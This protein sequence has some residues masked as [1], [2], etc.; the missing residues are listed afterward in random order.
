LARLPVSLDGLPSP[1]VRETGRSKNGNENVSPCPIRAAAPGRNRHGVAVAS[2]ASLSGSAFA[3]PTA[4]SP[5]LASAAAPS[6]PHVTVDRARGAAD[7]SKWLTPAVRA[8]I[9]KAGIAAAAA[10]PSVAVAFSGFAWCGDDVAVQWPAYDSTHDVTITVPA[11]MWSGNPQDPPPWNVVVAPFYV[12]QVGTDITFHYLDGVTPP[13]GPYDYWNAW[14]EWSA[15]SPGFFVQLVNVIWTMDNG[16]LSLPDIQVVQASVRTQLRR[17]SAISSAPRS[18]RARPRPARAGA[19]P[20]A[21][22]AIDTRLA[23][24]TV[25]SR[26]LVPDDQNSASRVHPRLRLTA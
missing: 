8:K 6:G 15:P 18:A 11:I 25:R 4:V 13:D 16:Q 14:T 1:P 26:G 10:D 5:T 24:V 7:S 19:R 9:A 17:P 20:G 12:A 23:P 2:I 21:P 3:A 22:P